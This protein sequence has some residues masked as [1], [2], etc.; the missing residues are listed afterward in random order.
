MDKKRSVSVSMVA[1]KAGVSPAT[2]SRILHGS[3]GVSEDKRKR[4]QEAL[5]ELGAMPRMRGLDNSSNKNR[6]IAVLIVSPDGLHTNS[7]DLYRT[8]LAVESILRSKRIDMIFG[9]IDEEAV[10]PRAVLAGKVDAVL[11]AGADYPSRLR[12]MLEGMP[13]LWL[14]SHHEGQSG[15]T[16]AGNEDIGRMA[17]DYLIERGHRH[18]AYFKIPDSHPVHGTRGEFFA[19]AA[20]RAGATVEYFR[21]EPTRLP[22]GDDVDW[23]ALYEDVLKQV[24]RLK[25]MKPRP[26]GAFVPVGM[27]VGLI[28]RALEACGLRPG[29]DMEVIC[30]EQNRPLIASLQ[31]RPARIQVDTHLVAQC[32]VEEIMRQME[33]PGAKARPIKISVAPQLILGD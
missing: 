10:L 32:A 8:I 5:D 23:E 22:G 12:S 4:V 18:L 1:K 9:T 25:A 6:T 24:Q 19:F 33:D 15:F 31:P 14:S 2:V 3:T 30:C 29:K 7:A 17:G 21:S 13:S 28:Y 27:F 26:T 20:S 16:L 11:L